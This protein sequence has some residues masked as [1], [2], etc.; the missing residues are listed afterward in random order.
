MKKAKKFLVDDGALFVHGRR[1][2]TPFPVL[3]YV[4][5][6]NAVIVLLRAPAG[7]IYNRNIHAYSTQGQLLWTI[8][9]T[10]HGGTKDQPYV[11]IEATSAG[12]VARNWNGV[13]YV[14]DLQTGSIEVCG[15]GK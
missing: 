11:G 7:T 1:I 8:P 14:I 9:E 10:P 6:K 3:Q 5:D 12:L 15:F 4:V 13:E 2:S